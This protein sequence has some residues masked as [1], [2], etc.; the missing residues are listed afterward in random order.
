MG[1][2]TPKQ[3]LPLKGKTVLEHTLSRLLAEPQIQGIVVALSDRDG[4]WSQLDLA[5][6]PRITRAQGGRER[7]H[8]VLNGLKA[9]SR[10]D[11]NG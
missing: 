7:G 4:R 3:Y 8:S 11:D 5:Q 9:L 2:T 1:S 10:A 6:D